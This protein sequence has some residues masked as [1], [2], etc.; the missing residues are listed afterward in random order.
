M[1]GKMTD[2]GH[3]GEVNFQCSTNITSP[4][5]SSLQLLLL[6][7]SVGIKRFIKICDV[8]VKVTMF[9]E[10]PPLGVDDDLF[11]RP[12]FISRELGDL[13]H[14]LHVAGISTSS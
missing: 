9:P 5:P 3:H 10:R 14:S 1:E 2:V 6:V 12:P 13:V 8:L 11:V 7:L 4:P